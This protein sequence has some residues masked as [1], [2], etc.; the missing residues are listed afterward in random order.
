MVDKKM[1]LLEVVTTYIE[2]RC[3]CNEVHLVWLKNYSEC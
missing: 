1:S 2:A 3:V